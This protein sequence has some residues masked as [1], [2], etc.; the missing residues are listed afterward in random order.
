MKDVVSALKN[1]KC[2]YLLNLSKIDKYMEAALS[3]LFMY[4]YIC[5]LMNYVCGITYFYM[6]IKH[7]GGK[8][9]L[10]YDYIHLED[11]TT[12]L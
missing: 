4:V 6:I 11:C 12:S 5:Y 8:L 2:V 9:K 1:S 10:A 7:L 3:H